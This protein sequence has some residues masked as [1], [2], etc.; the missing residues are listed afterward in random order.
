M[1]A[2]GLQCIKVKQVL[3]SITLTPVRHKRHMQFLISAP[4]FRRL[5]EPPWHGLPKPLTAAVDYLRQYG[6]GAESDSA[7]SVN[8]VPLFEVECRS[9]K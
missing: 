4:N 2:C 5:V 9:K 7:D 6:T 3:I 1:Q 8:P